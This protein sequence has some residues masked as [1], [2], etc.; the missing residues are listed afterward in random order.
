MDLNLNVYVNCAASLLKN[1]FHK[2]YI[3]GTTECV[4]DVDHYLSF[5]GFI[6][7]GQ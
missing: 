1:A 7:L 5:I 6:G 4:D 3:R 2:E